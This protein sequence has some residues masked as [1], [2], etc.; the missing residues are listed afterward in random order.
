VADIAKLLEEVVA[1]RRRQ[2]ERLVGLGPEASADEVDEAL[3][4]LRLAE[5][6]LERAREEAAF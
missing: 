1:A 4:R 3:V 6:D 5:V 2:Y